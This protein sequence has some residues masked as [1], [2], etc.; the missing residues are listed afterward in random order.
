MACRSS[1]SIHAPVWGATLTTKSSILSLCFNPRTRVGCD[2]VKPSLNTAAPVSIHAPVWGAT[3]PQGC[4]SCHPS[5]NPR[6]RV[7]CDMKICISHKIVMFQS[8]H[9]CGVR[10][11]YE[12]ECGATKVSIHAPVWGAT[13]PNQPK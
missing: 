13:Y 5:F 2:S 9:P 10:R 3:R 8:T 12:C 11:V 1:V 4:Y 7:G 6:T